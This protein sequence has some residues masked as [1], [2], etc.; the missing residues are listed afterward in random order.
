MFDRRTALFA[1]VVLTASSGAAPAQPAGFVKE[2]SQGWVRR[3]NGSIAS[4]TGAFRIK[5]VTQGRLVVQASPKLKQVEYQWVQRVPINL[6]EEAV[7]SIANAAK[8]KAVEQGEWCLIVTSLPGDESF[9]ELTVT[10]PETFSVA[11]LE[12]RAGGLRLSRLSGDIQ[13]ATGAGNV[14]IDTISGE[15]II[16][17]G[18]GTVSAGTVK[19]SLRCLSNGGSIK[20]QE[21]AGDTILETA[22]GEIF[23]QRGGGYARLSTAGGNIHVGKSARNV[24]AHTASGSIEVNESGGI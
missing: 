8:I 2:G 14:D 20:V 16:R 19:G 5:V 3:Q 21:V 17:T 10:V 11:R 24:F 1:L 15:V 4:R 13:A 22:G 18:G 9:S 23:L 6:G 12:T 7:E